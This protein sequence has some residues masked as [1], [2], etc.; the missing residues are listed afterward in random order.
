LSSDGVLGKL[1][2]I[3]VYIVARVCH[4]T[5]PLSRH[6]TAGSILRQ[7]SLLSFLVA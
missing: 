1:S 2:I 4:V 5:T 7:L 3:F 6:G